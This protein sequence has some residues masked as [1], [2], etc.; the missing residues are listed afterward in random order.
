LNTADCAVLPHKWFGLSDPVYARLNQACLLAGKLLL[1]FYNDDDGRPID[2]LGSTTILFRTS[3]DAR[4]HARYPLERPMVPLIPDSFTNVLMSATTP[5]SV[6]FCGN[7]CGRRRRVLDELAEGLPITNFIYRRGHWAPGIDMHVARSEFLENMRSSLFIV[8]V[9]GAGNFSYRLY[10]TL[11]MGRIPILVHTDGM[12][13][14]TERL[15]RVCVC[16]DWSAIGTGRLVE[17]VRA[18][19]EAHYGALDEAQRACRALWVQCYSGRGILE[20]VYETVARPPSQ[21]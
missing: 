20:D 17:A 16:V 11:M 15:M 10:E 6:G 5:I 4:N 13:P 19:H 1:A 18:F 21:L 14:A 2:G 9:R 12:Y 8:C 7:V 3:M